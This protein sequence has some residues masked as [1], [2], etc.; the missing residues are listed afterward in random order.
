M[1]KVVTFCRFL[2]WINGPRFDLPRRSLVMACGAP[3]GWLSAGHATAKT[4]GELRRRK[5]GTIALSAHDP[6]A[7]IA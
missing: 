6:L 1:H 7:G 2:S 3:M 5:A 4:G